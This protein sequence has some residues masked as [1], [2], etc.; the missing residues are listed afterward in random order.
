M[1]YSG[2]SMQITL[3]VSLDELKQ[4][5]FDTVAGRF[6]ETHEQLYTF[7]LEAEK[8]LIN[9]RAVATSRSTFARAQEIESGDTD[10]N[11]ARISQQSV[12]VDRA[13]HNANVYDRARLEAGNRIIG[14]A[15]ITEMDS[16]TLI[17]PNHIGEVDK[18]GNILIRPN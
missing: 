13:D 14:P 5:G 10:P 16:T 4:G 17:L 12:F 9:L 8:E 7:R 1:R 3:D 15:I 6:D 11:A 18:F 2:Q